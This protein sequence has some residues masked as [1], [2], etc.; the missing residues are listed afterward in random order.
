MSTEPYFEINPDPD[1]AKHIRKEREKARILKR[2][3]WWKN[4]LHKGTCH[5]CGQQFKADELSMDHIVPLA[6]GGKSTKGNI[7]PSCVEC[8]RKKKL[9]TPA[10]AVLKKLSPPKKGTEDLY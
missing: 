9:E 3:P 7:V 6:R 1:T 8:N 4:Q 2:T 5:Y 10:E